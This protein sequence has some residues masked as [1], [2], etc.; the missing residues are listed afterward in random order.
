M[1]TIQVPKRPNCQAAT[2]REGRLEQ[3]LAAA[4]LG[5]EEPNA[6]RMA[7]ARPPSLHCRQAGFQRHH[8]A[9]WH[10]A[11]ARTLPL[12]GGGAQEPLRLLR[13]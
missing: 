3:L 13:S 9:N 1:E 7:R 2:F 5:G 10:S 8:C 6:E 12:R 11:S 4:I